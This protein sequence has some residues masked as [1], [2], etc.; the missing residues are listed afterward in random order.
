MKKVLAV[1]LAVV[2]A[3]SVGTTAFALDLVAEPSP[4]AGQVTLSVKSEYIEA[5]GVYNLPVSIISAYTPTEVGASPA[6]MMGFTLGLSGVMASYAEITGFEFTDAL[7]GTAGFTVLDEFGNESD[8]MTVSFIVP[9][10]DLLSTDRTEIGYVEITVKDTA[11]F[12]N[13]DDALEV[14]AMPSYTGAT[15]GM[16]GA[17]DTYM[18]DGTYAAGVASGVGMAFV[19]MDLEGNTESLIQDENLFANPATCYE[20]P[21]VIPWTERIVN[22]LKLWGYQIITGLVSLLSVA[23]S[24]LKPAA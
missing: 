6:V 7:K 16:G 11:V 5:D 15:L 21:P 3:F 8:P 2:L 13:E 4:T 1:L 22:L 19:V 20:K 14:S 24:F 10:D 12:E 9:G 23:Q 17:F 18:S